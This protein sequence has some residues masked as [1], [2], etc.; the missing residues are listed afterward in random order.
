MLAAQLKRFR[1]LI[2]PGL[3]D[4]GPRHWQTL[5]QHQYPAFERVEQRHWNIPDVERWS[6]QISNTLRRSARPA[7][8]AAHSFGC[9]AS[10]HCAAP[11]VRTLHGIFMV[12]PADPEKFGIGSLL[13]KAVFSCPVTVVASDNDPWMDADRAA[14]WARQWGAKFIN[15]GKLGHINADSGLGMWPD[16]LAHFERLLQRI[17]GVQ[18]CACAPAPASDDRAFT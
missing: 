12:A 8:I 18:T 3:G 6:E 5:W 4:S 10:A 16:G 17:S 1:I 13:R 7:V 15:A 11:G 9:L 14:W 2:V